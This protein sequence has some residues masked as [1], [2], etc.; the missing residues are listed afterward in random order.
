MPGA[1]AGLL[2]ARGDLAAAVV[3]L[4]DDI[5]HAGGGAGAVDRAAGGGQHLDALD[6]ADG[7]IVDRRLRG[8]VA[9]P[10]RGTRNPGRRPAAVD[11]DHRVVVVPTAERKRVGPAI[12]KLRIGNQLRGRGR[13]IL[14]EPVTQKLLQIRRPREL[15]IPCGKGLEF[16]RV[17]ARSQQVGARRREGLGLRPVHHVAV[18]GHEVLFSFRRDLAFA[19]SPARRCHEPDRLQ[20]RGRAR[21]HLHIGHTHR[22]QSADRRRDRL[23]AHR[24]AG[25]HET[26]V[27]LR[28]DPARAPDQRDPRACQRCARFRVQQQ[29]LDRAG[30]RRLGPA[31]HEQAHPAQAQTKEITGSDFHR[32]GISN[33]SAHALTK[34]YSLRAPRLSPRRG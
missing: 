5:D 31:F 25:E 30:A 4:R 13:R 32:E 19:R 22:P 15:Q 10:D 20:R 11:E 23:R 14:R 6:G 12:R 16:K 9:I 2:V 21:R 3:A 1:T 34:P 28:H 17:L 26:P 24:H 8:A 33:H 29:A 27:R 18:E 7:H